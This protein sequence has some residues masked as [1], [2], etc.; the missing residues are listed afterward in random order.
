MAPR[1][2]LT[3]V[4]SR[5][6]DDAQSW[7]IDTYLSHDGYQALHKALAMTPDEVIAAVTD[8]GLRGRGGAGYPRA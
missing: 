4:L 5:H 2:S 6:W 3:P 1:T 8:S 7:T